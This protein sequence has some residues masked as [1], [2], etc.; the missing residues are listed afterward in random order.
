MRTWILRG[1]PRIAL[2]IYWACHVRVYRWR[3]AAELA[4]DYME[5]LAG[6]ACGADGAWRLLRHLALTEE[7]DEEVQGIEAEGEAGGGR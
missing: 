5:E 4:A 7:L 2:A 6:W 3:V 1:R